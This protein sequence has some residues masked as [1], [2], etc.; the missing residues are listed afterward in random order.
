M[1]DD[2]SAYEMP[3]RLPNGDILI[4]RRA[5]APPPAGGETDEA[6][7]DGSEPPIGEDGEVE[8]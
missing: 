8:L 4:R 3:E 7:P 5:D 1:I 6:S 2:L